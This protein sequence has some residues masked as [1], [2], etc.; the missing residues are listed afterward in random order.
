[1]RFIRVYLPSLL[2]I[3]L[4]LSTCL[5]P[6]Q[7]LPQISLI[8]LPIPA[9][10]IIHFIYYFALSTFIYLNTLK[11]KDY[12]NKSQIFTFIGIICLTLGI[13]IEFAQEYVIINRSASISDI[14]AN[15]TGYVTFLFFHSFIE[16][17][18]N[19]FII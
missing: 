10:K 8:K 6:G 7:H 15:M 4:I 9:D 5:V 12:S 13:I 17:Q 18:Y 16:R 19:K 2:W 14:I 1:M 3:L 11:N